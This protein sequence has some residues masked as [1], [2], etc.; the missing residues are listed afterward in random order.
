[1]EGTILPV[2]CLFLPLCV[3]MDPEL[4]SISRL[5]EL[6]SNTVPRIGRRATELQA[7]ETAAP[8]TEDRI[9]TTVL[10]RVRKRGNNYVDYPSWLRSDLA[11]VG[12]R[13]TPRFG[14]PDHWKASQAKRGM[15]VAELS[16][17]LYKDITLRKRSAQRQKTVMPFWSTHLYRKPYSGFRLHG[18]D[19]DHMSQSVIYKRAQETEGEGQE[20]DK[21]VMVRVPREGVLQEP[22]EETLSRLEYTAM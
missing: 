7:E 2:F 10:Q 14:I 1:M 11:R 19:L 13:G 4:Q 15:S 22:R 6:S 3:S 18:G 9:Q 8:E 5:F 21:G 12:K 16:R 20:S 17:R